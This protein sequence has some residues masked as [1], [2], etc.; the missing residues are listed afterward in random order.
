MP[1]PRSVEEWLAQI[2]EC[3]HG[4]SPYEDYGPCRACLIAGL[5]GFA[6]QERDTLQQQVEALRD[7]ILSTSWPLALH[8]KVRAA[9]CGGG[10]G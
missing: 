5:K 7:L 2:D 1:E 6:A 4:S 8:E 3:Q 10:A 9:L